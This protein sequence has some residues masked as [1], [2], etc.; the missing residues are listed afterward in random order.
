[1]DKN[2][3]VLK[4]DIFE[5]LTRSV[6]E[7][8]INHMSQLLIGHGSFVWSYVK[9]K[10]GKAENAWSA[11]HGRARHADECCSHGE[12][13]L[14]QGGAGSAYGGRLHSKGHFD[15]NVMSSDGKEAMEQGQH[16]GAKKR[17]RSKTSTGK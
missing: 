13:S 4:P 10:I 11:W 6:D 15:T 17:R 3:F 2:A 7:L 5:D 1:M 14:R 8:Y 16:K 12:G 9:N